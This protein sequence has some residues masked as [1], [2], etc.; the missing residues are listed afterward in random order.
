MIKHVEKLNELLHPDL[1]ASKEAAIDSEAFRLLSSIGRECVEATQGS[2][3]QFDSATYM[4]KLVTFMG[5]RRMDGAGGRDK[6][7]SSCLDWGKLGGRAAVIFHKR[8][9]PTN[10]V[11]VPYSLSGPNTTH[12]TSLIS[13]SPLV[14]THFIYFSNL[15]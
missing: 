11:C 5:G 15:I 4:E 6:N 14:S 7:L 1:H 9:P 10:F 3:V 12:N 13:P 8:P 2:I